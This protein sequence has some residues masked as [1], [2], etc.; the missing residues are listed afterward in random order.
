MDR[1]DMINLCN[2][3][4]ASEPRAAMRLAKPNGS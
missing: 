3:K 1:Q 4:A 2:D